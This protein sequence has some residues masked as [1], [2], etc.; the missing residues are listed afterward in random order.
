LTGTSGQ[1][2][3]LAAMVLG[4]ALTRDGYQVVQTQSYGAAARGGPTRAD[5]IVS[6]A[7]INDLTLEEP[8]LMLVLSSI[9]LERFSQYIGSKTLLVVEEQVKNNIEHEPIVIVP[10]TRLS[11]EKFGNRLYTNS[12][13]VGFLSSILG[14][15]SIQSLEQAVNETLRKRLEENKEAIFLGYSYGKSLE[16]KQ[17]I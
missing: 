10:S 3:I 7:P 15:P 5:V 16:S 4:D 8:D 12:V 2:V 14:M 9:A 17:Q 13:T 11:V 1:G 6:D